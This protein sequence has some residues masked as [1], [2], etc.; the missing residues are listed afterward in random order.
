MKLSVSDIAWDKEDDPFFYREMKRLHYRGLE[1]APTRIFPGAPY[2][3]LLEA[4]KWASGLRETYGL[5]LSSIQSIWYGKTERMFGSREEREELAAYTRKAIDFAH[6]VGCGNLVFGCPSNRRLEPGESADAG[7]AF[8]EELGRYAQTKGTVLSLEAN[9][10]IYHTNYMN[11]T[12]EALALVKQV[13]VDGFRL[14]LDLGAVI[15]NGESL[16][17]LIG[18]FRWIRHIHI[19]EPHLRAVK[20]RD[21]HRELAEILSCGQDY[22]GYISIEMGKGLEREDVVRIMGEV[23]ELYGELCEEI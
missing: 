20:V 6:A 3:R 7:M 16:E 9:P 1:I 2:D 18:E 15:Y 5:H 8:F 19:S 21:I 10:A 23:K 14:N 22:E 12:M 11:T 13:N 17:A 4:E